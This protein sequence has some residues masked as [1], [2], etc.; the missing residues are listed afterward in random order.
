MLRSIMARTSLTKVLIIDNH[1]IFTMGLSSLL[2]NS[3]KYNIIG[4]AVNSQDALRLTEN[5]RPKLII[6][7]VE[8]GSEN[9]MD[10]ITQ[11]KVLFPEIS[12]LVLSINEERYFSERVLRLGARGYIMKTAK[13]DEILNAVSTIMEGKV[14]LS[15]NERDRI[16][17]AISEDNIIGS[18]DWAV[19]LQ[20]LSNRELQVFTLIGKGF[21]TIEIATRL[22]LSTKTIDTH[23]E[24][25]KLKLHCT[26]SQEL[27][28]LAIEWSNQSGS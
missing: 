25:I 14:F 20:K 12:I 7:E 26:T 9:G 3:N 16:F 17:Q 2:E 24:H 10:L 18:R 22:D 6:M 28:Q 19:S 15:D 4:I 21:G 1:P 11:L 23:K 5:E 8:L 13:P 27:R